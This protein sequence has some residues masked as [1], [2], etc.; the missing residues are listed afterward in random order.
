MFF[1]KNRNKI[2]CF[3][4]L[5][6]YYLCFCSFCSPPLSL[7]TITIASNQN[8]HP[9]ICAIATLNTKYKIKKGAIFATFKCTSLTEADD[10]DDE[11][12]AQALCYQNNPGSSSPYVKM[13]S[14]NCSPDRLATE[15]EVK[16]KRVAL[17]GSIANN[18]ILMIADGYFKG[19]NPPNCA[20]GG[21]AGGTV[22]GAV[23]IP[24]SIII[25]LQPT[26]E[27]CSPPCSTCGATST[28]CTSCLSSHPKL[29]NEKCYA[30]CPDGTYS[31]SHF[32]SGNSIN[33][34]KNCLN[35]YSMLSPLC[36]MLRP[37]HMYYL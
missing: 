7:V 24:F 9:D 5:L 22:T 32:C 27:V 8:N 31:V 37:I 23:C 13:G 6:S 17:C 2:L 4:S 10:S 34:L 15:A 25:T 19:S 26:G 30:T 33:F 18:D 35:L 20:F 3:F 11:P 1:N 16:K 21:S 12:V 29:Y 28:T 14:T 36:E